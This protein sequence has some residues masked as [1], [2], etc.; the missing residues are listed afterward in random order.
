MGTIRLRL[1]KVAA[2]VIQS[3]R[4]VVFHLASSYPYRTIFQQVHERLTG[5]PSAAAVD[6]S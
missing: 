2:R 6:G 4:R 5:P 3:V 1:F